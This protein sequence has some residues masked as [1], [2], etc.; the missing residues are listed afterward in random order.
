MPN[1]SRDRSREYDVV[2]WGATGFTGRL[3]AEYLVETYLRPAD[4]PA[5]L[6]LAVAGRD[7]AKLEE[8]ARAIG[9]SELPILIGDSFDA[10]SLDSL[11]A[12]TEVV[13]STVGPYARYGAELV[14]A[15]V[16]HGT[17]YCDLTG[18]T[19]FVRRMIDAH[20]EEAAKTGAR[21]V[22]CCGYDSVPSD[23]GTLMVQEAMFARHGVYAG[24]VK[25][26][27]GESK[28]GLSGGTF[29][30]MLQLLDE[31]KE[32]PRLRHLLGDPYALNPEGIRG[33]D[34]RDQ[35]G[36]RYDG[37]LGMWTAPFIM[38]GIN[39]R[40]VR[41]S[42]ALLGLPWGKTFRYSEV[43]ST[44]TGPKGLARAVAL[45]GGVGAF[46]ALVMLPLTKP[47]IVR[48]LPAPG[49]GPSRDHRERGYF[50]T[51][52]LALGNGK[53]VRGLVAGFKDPGYGSTAIMLGE[54]A[55]CL[56]LDGPELSQGGG[57]W[58]PASCMGMRLVDRL[59]A[60]G[61]TFDVAAEDGDE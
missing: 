39:T 16:R 5:K 4:H 30:S 3:V 52:L 31:L 43:A 20:H 14:A 22:H 33:D 9:A 50:K 34:R 56:L 57:V 18:E 44:G 8:V 6:R 25:M 15:C 48:K 51:R 21:I 35:T 53:R 49:E 26:A 38:A 10:P 7:R 59:R 40:V 11:A 12:R 29:A 24:E 60:A 47:F 1:R 2:L 13:I 46:M 36:V 19:Q 27:A 58:T 42:H 28:G 32:N 41:R 23:L 37:D 54:S 17:D 45:A 55:M 61:M